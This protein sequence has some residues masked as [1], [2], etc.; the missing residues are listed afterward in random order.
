MMAKRKGKKRSPVICPIC[1][2]PR[3]EPGLPLTVPFN[4]PTYWDPD[5]ALA[6]FELIDELRDTIRNIYGPKLQAAARQQYGPLP[7]DS[8]FAPE[9]ELP[10]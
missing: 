9:D 3:R 4:I 6:V 5:E 2:E 10:F 7:G 8:A 1:A